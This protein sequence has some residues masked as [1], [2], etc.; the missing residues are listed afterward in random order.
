M[1]MMWSP[2]GASSSVSPAAIGK[3]PSISFIDMVPEPSSAVSCSSMESEI[4]DSTAVSVTS[5]SLSFVRRPNEEV[6]PSSAALTQGSSMVR[7]AVA[8]AASVESDWEEESVSDPAVESWPHAATERRTAAVSAGRT[9]EVRVRM[10]A[11]F[12]GCGHPPGKRDAKVERV[13]GRGRAR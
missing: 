2:P 12:C 10:G 8:W 3:P 9:K 5:S 13:P 1:N 4:E 7:D 6:M 11:P